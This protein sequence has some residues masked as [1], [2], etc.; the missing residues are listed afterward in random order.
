MANNLPT[1]VMEA[2]SLLQNPLAHNDGDM[3]R[4]IIRWGYEQIDAE[5]PEDPLRAPLNPLKRLWA[6]Q[7]W[8]RI[9]R[10]NG[11]ELRNVVAGAA[12]EEL[13]FQLQR[14]QHQ[15]TARDAEDL[16]QEQEV[17]NAQLRVQEAGQMAAL[18][19]T[20]QKDLLSW[21]HGLTQDAEDAA[22]RRRLQEQM[23]AADLEIRNLLTHAIIK[24]S[25]ASTA[26]ETI[27][28]TRLVNE[29][30]TRIRHD[31]NLSPDEQH[32]QIK[33]L[34]DTMP[35]MLRNLRPHDV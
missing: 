6:R 32:V 8:D 22:S 17:F 13:K 29:E 28:A 27:R 26:D 30:I 12:V 31:P 2:G 35:G 10:T 19:H 4:Q 21:Q 7:E 15:I 33:N 11:R 9:V 18:Q 5:Y 3:R 34:L 16:R 1:R 24:A 20:N 25:G 14:R 23:A